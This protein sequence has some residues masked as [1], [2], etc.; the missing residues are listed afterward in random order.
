MIRFDGRTIRV[1][2]ATDNR[3][4]SGN[5]GGRGGGGYSR[6]AYGMAQGGSQGYLGGGQQLMNPPQ[7]PYG[8]GSPYAG[9][10]YPGY[11]QQQQP[12]GPSAQGDGTSQRPG[13]QYGQQQGHYQN[14][15]HQQ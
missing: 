5:R 8:R 6:G 1:D 3:G 7:Y 2:H 4:S 13:G 15:S 10:Q 14:R 12:P 11:H 9:A